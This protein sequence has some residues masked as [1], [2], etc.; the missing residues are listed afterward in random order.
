MP[1]KPHKWGMK[2]YLLTLLTVTFGTGS[3]THGRKNLLEEGFEAC[4]TLRSNRKGIPDDVKTA[5]LRKGETKFTKDDCFI[6]MKWRDKRDVLMMSTFH[7]D[8]FIEKRR[9]TRL[10]TDGVEVINKPELVEVYNQ[11]MGGVDNGKCK[12]TNTSCITY[13]S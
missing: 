6:V 9:R 2:A 7:D 11:N 3:C 4:G 10:A 8:T 12:H 5:Q 13:L 1:K